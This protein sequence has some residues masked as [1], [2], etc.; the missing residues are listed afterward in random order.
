MVPTLVVSGPI[1]AGKTTSA[2]EVADRLVARQVAHALIE[3][4][5]LAQVW[6]A[7]KDDRFQVRLAAANLAAV[8]SNAVRAGA[9][10]LVLTMTVETDADLAAVHEAVPELDL[11]VVRLMATP[12]TLL[13][14]V[15]AR[16]P[17]A[18]RAWHRRRA[19]ELHASMVTAP[20]DVVL[21]TTDLTVDEVADRLVD[22]VAWAQAPSGG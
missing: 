14:R 6:P 16:E 20:A 3:I 8:W 22:L 10:N 4:D 15:G 1:G 13:D 7:P 11:T 21:D 18:A 9:R 5:G 19:L 17:G 12:R 2:G